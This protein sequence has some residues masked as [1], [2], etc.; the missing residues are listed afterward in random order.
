MVR[1]FKVLLLLLV[2][3]L[4]AAAQGDVQWT[5]SLSTS[6]CNV[7]DQVVLELKLA[8]SNVSPLE[9]RMPD[10]PGVGMEFAGA[11]KNLTMINGVTA[12]SSSFTYILTPQQQGTFTIPAIPMSVEGVS[13]NTQP[14]QLQVGTSS[15]VPSQPS[16]PPSFPQPGNPS[17]FP[18][19]PP[20]FEPPIQGQ[21]PWGGPVS[22]AQPVLVECEVSTRTP[23]V[24]QLVVYTFRFLHRV[25]LAGN[26]NYEPA[27]ATGFLRE[28]LGQST[29]TVER[30][31]VTYSVS[32]VKTA[33]FPTS[34]GKVTIGATR[35]TCRLTPDLFDTNLA[36]SDPVRELST[37]PIDLEVQALPTQNRPPSFTGAVGSGFELQASLN[38]SQV[39]AGEP[40]K[41]TMT[42]TGN[43]HPDLILDPALP[44]WPHVRAYAWENQTPAFEKPNYR[45]SKI[46]KIP[47]VPQQP[48]KLSL[49]NLCWSYFD[50]A[51]QRY[52]TL[53]AN[54]LAVDVDGT[55]VATDQQGKTPAPGQPAVAVLSGPQLGGDPANRWASHPAAAAVALLP[56]LLSLILLSLD[57][58]HQQLQLHLQTT[59]ARLA[60]LEKKISRARSLEDLSHLAYQ[61]LSLR[62]DTALNGL[63]F[64]R[65]RELLSA[66]MVDQLEQAEAARYAPQSDDDEKRVEAFRRL[67]IQELRRGRP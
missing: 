19:I 31:G 48:G 50:P 17:G 11:S 32:E 18:T 46:F 57:H 42:I 60:R 36:F 40:V 64:V 67:L 24:N 20:L 43:S 54:P 63:P 4:Y 56:W 62:L 66:E 22:N 25:G 35:L 13:Y 2:C 47:L 10:I 44:N 52:V 23:Y 53:T 6:R 39:K 26:P 28:E 14:I 9:P 49:S 55:P 51:Q 37:Q 8:G 41:L 16:N 12:S 27:P 59:Q 21:S 45:A 5:A 33:F 38:K 34:P 15:G 61:S 3:C 29:S 65:L 7:G 58:A 1:S 30:E